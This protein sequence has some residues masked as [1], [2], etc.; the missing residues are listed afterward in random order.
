MRKVLALLL[1]FAACSPAAEPTPRNET[2]VLAATTST[3]DSGILDA[4]TDRFEKDHPWRVKVVAVGSGEALDL[5][6][7]GDADVVLAHSPEAEKKFIAEGHGVSRKPVMRN[8]FVIA[9]TESDPAH[10]RDESSAVEAFERIARSESL[11][12]SRGDESGTHTREL[13]TWKT[14]G[15][16]L[17]GNWYLSTGQGMAETLIVA[18][19]RK[20]YVLT[21]TATLR[22]MGSKIE[23]EVLFEGD[24]TLDN[25][26]HV[27]PVKRARRPEA[28]EAFATWITGAG[29]AFI[30]EFG[31]VQYGTP[32]FV[33]TAST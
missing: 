30:A 2:F 6:R 27:I 14:A 28:A 19:E 33:P 10:V 1:L 22:V 3:Q 17:N 8:D 25:P 16:R 7:R 24:K 23:L 11:F 15:I 9:G 13:E 29:Q 21:D 12:V 26:Y 18:S 31:R 20:A 32:L 4:L 5:G